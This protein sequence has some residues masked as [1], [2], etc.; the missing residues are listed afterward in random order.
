MLK[1][2]GE[3]AAV[4]GP[5]VVDAGASALRAERAGFAAGADGKEDGEDIVRL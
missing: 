2:A 1:T 5:D 3:E 4:D